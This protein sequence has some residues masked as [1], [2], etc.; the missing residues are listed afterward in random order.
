MP[1]TLPATTSFQTTMDTII[2]TRFM[3][4][5]R[6]RTTRMMRTTTS[7]L[8]RMSFLMMTMRAMS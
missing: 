5:R 1:F 8:M 3:I 6:R 2:T 4:P 7:P